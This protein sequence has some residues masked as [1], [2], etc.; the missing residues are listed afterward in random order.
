MPDKLTVPPSENTVRVRMIDSTARFTLQAESFFE[1]SQRGLQ[2]YEVPDVAFLID[3]EPSG[4]AVMFDLGVRKDYWNLPKVMLHRLSTDIIS[5]VKIDSDVPD[6]LLENGIMLEKISAV[7]WSHYHWDHIGDMSLFPFSTSL[8]VGPGFKA[9][10]NLLP[11][12]PLKEDSPVSANAFTGRDLEEIDF[13]QSELTIGGFR[14]FDFFSDGSFYLLDTPGHCIGHIC[15]F[16]RTSVGPESSFVFLGGDICHFAGCFR[17]SP[18]SPL[19]P[20]IP[21]G[22]LDAN[23]DHSDPFPATTFTN[24]YSAARPDEDPLSTPFSKI[25]T[26]PTSAFAFPDVSQQTVEKLIAFDTSPQVLICFAHD[27]SLPLFLPT[28]NTS[29]KE[30]LNDWR[31]KGLKEQCHWDWLN[32]LPTGKSSGRTPVVQEMWKDG[33]PWP[34]GKDKLRAK[35]R[36][37]DVT[38]L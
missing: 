34:G 4:R 36:G 9:A 38:E 30:C 19:P 11:G 33:K 29:P 5:N 10:P 31:S 32:I 15:G 20:I 24:S 3:H 12:Y 13:S 1:P 21:A 37:E 28:M 23:D 17:P 14:A 25:S 18:D 16:A 26:I 35:S 7:I 2:C 8:V 27:Q 22:I 6:I